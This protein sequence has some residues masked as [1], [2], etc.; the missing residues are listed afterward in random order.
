VGH[1]GVS[2]GISGREGEQ[3]WEEMEMPDISVGG[4]RCTY[5]GKYAHNPNINR[6]PC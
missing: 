6:K 4:G 2:P 3:G 5:R 1:L